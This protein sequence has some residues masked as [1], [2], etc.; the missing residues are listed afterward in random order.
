MKNKALV[1]FLLFIVM[2]AM[3]VALFV[4]EELTSPAFLPQE[5]DFFS[6]DMISFDCREVVHSS[7]TN[8]LAVASAGL[9]IIRALVSGDNA[10]V[11]RAKFVLKSE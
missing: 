4:Y 9:H 1:G 5:C 11:E 6:P 10:V 7:K 3:S 2:A 8:P